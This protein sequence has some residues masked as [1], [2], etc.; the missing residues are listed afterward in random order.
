MEGLFEDMVKAKQTVNIRNVT[1]VYDS[2]KVAVNNLS[3][4][5]YKN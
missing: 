3:M 2:G 1:K 4:N 5:M